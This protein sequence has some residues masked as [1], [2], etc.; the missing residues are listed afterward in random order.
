MYIYNK[1]KWANRCVIADRNK[2]RKEKKRQR[3]IPVTYQVQK[4]MLD[5][6]LDDMVYGSS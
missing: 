2:K 3:L 6:K 4:R 5:R 1:T